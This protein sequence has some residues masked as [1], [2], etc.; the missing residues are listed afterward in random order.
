MLAA[1]SEAKTRTRSV[2]KVQTPLASICRVF[3][4]T[5]TQV[6]SLGLTH[7]DQHDVYKSY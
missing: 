3:V 7:Y 4:T 5:N 1:K 2:T 6:W